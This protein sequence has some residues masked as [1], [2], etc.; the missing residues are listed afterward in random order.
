MDIL[1]ILNFP[2]HDMGYLS[3][4]N[5]FPQCF[6]VFSE[7][8]FNSL[9]KFITKNFIHFGVIVNGIVFLLRKNIFSDSSVLVY[10][11]IT[12]FDFIFCNFT[13]YCF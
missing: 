10:R 9:V 13:K 1:I 5:F 6:V 4:L 12:A 3:T 8:D 11:N 7:E 2:I